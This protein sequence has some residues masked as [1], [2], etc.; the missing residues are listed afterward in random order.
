MDKKIEIIEKYKKM[1]NRLS[2]QRTDALKQ[3]FEFVLKQSELNK[4]SKKKE[5][6][7][8]QSKHLTDVQ[9]N[10]EHYRV[11]KRINVIK[12]KPGG[13]PSLDRVIL[14]EQSKHTQEEVLKCREYSHFICEKNIEK[15]NYEL[16][17][18]TQKLILPLIKK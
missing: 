4:N 6:E 3:H 18:K 9:P 15:I 10:Q 2:K 14:N 8:M 1:S 12:Y 7:N 17:E 11:N 5:N 13:G 16:K